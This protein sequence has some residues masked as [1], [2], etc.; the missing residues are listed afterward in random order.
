MKKF[1]KVYIEITNVCNLSCSFCPK[2]KREKKFLNIEEFR[3]R[4]QEVKPYTKYLYFHLMGEPLLNPNLKQFLTIANEEGFKVNLTTNGTLLNKNREILLAA[5]SLRQINISL[6]SFEANDS[7]VDFEEYLYNIIDFIQ[8]ANA[9]SNIIISMRLWNLDSYNLRGQNKLNS[10]IITILRDKFGYQYD[11]EEII[12]RDKKVKIREN[13]YLNS[14]EKFQWPDMDID[15]LGEKGFC[16]GLRDHFGILVDGTVVPCCL[17]GEGNIPLGN[18][19]DASLED[20]LSGERAENIYN[21]F[22]QRR[23]VE[24]LC[25]RCGYSDRF[26]IKK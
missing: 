14:A 2:T 18:I 6:H 8:E 13:L 25:K 10:N 4:L 11:L 3:Y 17:D 20:I 5:E 9:S 15:I 7:E 16:H 24:E 19:Y 12:S 1:K 26:S 22:S 21:G 23:R